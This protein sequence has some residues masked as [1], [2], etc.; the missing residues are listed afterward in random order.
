MT[1]RIDPGESSIVTDPQGTFDFSS[2]PVGSF[3]IRIDRAGYASVVEGI[4]VTATVKPQIER[5]SERQLS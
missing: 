2:V 1:V 3:V 4:S 5:P